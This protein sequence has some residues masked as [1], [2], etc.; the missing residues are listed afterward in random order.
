MSLRHNSSLSLKSLQDPSGKMLAASHFHSIMIIRNAYNIEVLKSSA[1]DRIHKL[2]IRA[3]VIWNEGNQL[4]LDIE[5]EIWN[6]HVRTIAGRFQL[7][8]DMH[9]DTHTHSSCNW[10]RQPADIFLFDAVKYYQM[11]KTDTFLCSNVISSFDLW[12]LISFIFY[13]Y[14]KCNQ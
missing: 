3:I 10:V 14:S 1:T 5:I 12:H 2:V 7:D 4:R 6:K 9:C 13:S 8:G 11:M